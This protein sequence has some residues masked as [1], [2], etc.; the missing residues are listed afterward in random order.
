M[1]CSIFN[2]YISTVVFLPFFP[3]PGIVAVLFECN[4]YVS[5]CTHVYNNSNSVC[6]MTNMMSISDAAT[7]FHFWG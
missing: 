4:Q 3:A 5:A 7:N 1:V 6:S 2:D